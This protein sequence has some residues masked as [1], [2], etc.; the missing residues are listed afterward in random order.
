MHP[1][2]RHRNLGLLLMSLALFFVGPV[3]AQQKCP[4]VVIRKARQAHNIFST[5]QEL[6]LA[7]IEAELLEES[8]QVI[9]HTGFA[10]HVTAVNNRLRSTLPAR[11]ADIRIVLIDTPEAGAF[12][13][14]PSRI[15]ITRK[16][17]GMLRSDDELAGLLGHELA[18][19]LTHENAIVVSQV[20]QEFLDVSTVG[21]RTDIADKFTRMLNSP[22][23]NTRTLPS[24]AQSGQRE[25]KAQYEADRFALYAMAAAGFSPRAYAQLFDRIAATYGNRG[26]LLTD[27]FGIT[28]PNERRLRQIYKS[29]HSLPKAYRAIPSPPTSPEF[30]AWQ[31][32][33]TSRVGLN[34][35]KGDPSES[36]PHSTPPAR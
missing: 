24:T 33:V 12:S 7:E 9:P 1:L 17:I 4:V 30:L 32:E 13:A 36:V 3:R 20:L 21:D 23:W 26:N 31:A 15:Y 14:G 34:S 19:T 18:H 28:T 8:Y 5:Q 35:Q 25:E 27:L 22:G 29:L 6:D 2:V 10:E 11:S 16:M